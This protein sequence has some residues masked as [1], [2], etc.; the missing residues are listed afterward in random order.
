MSRRRLPSPSLVISLLALFVALG[1]VGYAAA[2]IGTSDIKNQAVTSKKIR[3]RTIVSRDV[4]RNSLG[5]RAIAESRLRVGFA[6]SAGAA[7]TAQ[8]FASFAVVG[9]NGVLARGRNVNSSARSGAGRYQVIFN[10]NVRNCAFVGS[11]GV[12]GATTP[13]SG[14]ISTSALAS[15][16]NGVLVRTFNHQGGAEDKSF[17]LLVNC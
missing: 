15:N 4:R 16:I 1:G 12:I 2:T 6:G 13:G 3:N 17:H 5:P 8:G 9:A 10:R 7:G 11:V 14:M